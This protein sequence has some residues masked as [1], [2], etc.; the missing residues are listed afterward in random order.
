MEVGTEEIDSGGEVVGMEEVS[1]CGIKKCEDV[2][3]V[4]KSKDVER[5]GEE[6]KEIEIHMFCDTKGVPL[7][8]ERIWD[9]LI[10]EK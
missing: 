9:K 6:E 3:V 2:E 8:A 10:S 7:A 5:I 4:C 1:S